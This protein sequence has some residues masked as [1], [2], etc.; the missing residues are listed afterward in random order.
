MFACHFAPGSTRYQV[1]WQILALDNNSGPFYVHSM[2]IIFFTLALVLAFPGCGESTDP[3]TPGGALH[4]F[5]DRLL[6]HDFEGVYPMLSKKSRSVL[7]EAHMLLTEQR[8]AVNTVYPPEHRFGARGAYPAG[9]LASKV[10]A[11]PLA[12]HLTRVA[13]PYRCA[14]T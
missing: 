11:R 3:S 2:R 1:L 8:E 7:E 12:I 14:Q 4:Q 13:A 10:A 6:A 5:R 9:V